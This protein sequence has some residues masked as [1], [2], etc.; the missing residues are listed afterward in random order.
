MGGQTAKS[1]ARNRHRSATK[2]RK[3]KLDQMIL[4]RLVLLHQGSPV[5]REKFI[6][7]RSVTLKSLVARNFC[8]V[9]FSFG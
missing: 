3:S 5:G 6:V 2:K 4:S 9:M 8:N 1:I 7:K